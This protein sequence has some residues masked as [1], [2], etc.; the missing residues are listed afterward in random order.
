V[1]LVQKES[2]GY[3]WLASSYSNHKTIKV[4]ASLTPGSYVL[5]IL[6]EWKNKKHDFSLLYRGTIS[7]HF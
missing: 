6:P 5:I 1:I 4:S 3:R 2:D 7:T